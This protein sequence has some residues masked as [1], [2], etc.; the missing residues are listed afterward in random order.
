MLPSG[1]QTA[2]DFVAQFAKV[3]KGSV[4]DNTGAMLYSIAGIG[5]LTTIDEGDDLAGEVD[6]DQGVFSALGYLAR[7]LPPETIGNQDFHAEVLCLRTVDGLVP[8]SM[9][10]TRIKLPGGAPNEGAIAFA[11]YGGGF[12]VL[13]PVDSGEGGTIHVI[14]C[15]Y[16]FSDP[17]DPSTA[18]KAHSIMIDP[19]SGNESIMIVHGNGVGITMKDD[20]LV[21]KNAAGDVYCELTDTELILNGNIKVLGG[22]QTLDPTGL[23]SFPLAKSTE[24]LAMFAAIDLQLKAL[25]QAGV[26]PLLTLPTTNTYGF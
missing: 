19:T 9:R 22:F 14:Y 6:E 13:D 26:P 10:D 3:V 4:S 12:H 23:L 17:K 15:P 25:G 8:I 20:S 21:L 5:P 24:T 18:A 1:S 16:E 11:G 7:P 2:A